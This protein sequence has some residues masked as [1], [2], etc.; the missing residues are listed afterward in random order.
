M[1]VQRLL[2]AVQDKRSETLTAIA[3]SIHEICPELGQVVAVSTD[4]TTAGGNPTTY[5]GGVNDASA[6]AIN[7]LK[8]QI[9]Q[10]QAQ[11]SALTIGGRRR[12]FSC[13]KYRRRSRSRSPSRQGGLCFYHATYGERARNCSSPYTWKSGNGTGRT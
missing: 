13:A 7:E 5:G 8:E 12:P 11:V 6:A 1:Y 4:R 9:T 2:A 10:I 3:D